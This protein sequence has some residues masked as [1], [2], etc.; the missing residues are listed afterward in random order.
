MS[1][2][3]EIDR[4][5]KFGELKKEWAKLKKESKASD[6]ERN[7]AMVRI[8]AIQR[9][10]NLDI[11]TFKEIKYSPKSSQTKMSSSEISGGD[12]LVGVKAFYD[13]AG[14]FAF[15]VLEAYY[16]NN[17]MDPDPKEKLIA[18]EGLLKCFAQVWSHEK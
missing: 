9:E 3:T 5:A 13:E 15:D 10:M 14:K 2:T 7:E 16:A 12:K 4:K 1:E 18:W 6:K 17:M 11:T 8:N